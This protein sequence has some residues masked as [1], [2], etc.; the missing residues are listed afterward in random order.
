MFCSRRS[1]SN[2]RVDVANR[3]KK[4]NERNIMRKLKFKKIDAFSS[5]QSS[6]N[7]AGVIYMENFEE[8]NSDEMLKIAKELKD[9][10]SEVGFVC[11]ERNHNFKLRYYSS[12]REVE[13]CG[14]ATIAIMYDLIKNRKDLLNKQHIIINT[15]NDRL[16]V[17][18][19]ILSDNSIFITSPHPKFR[20]L[21]IKQN[22]IL[23]AL[24]V[25]KKMLDL[26]LDIS[27]INSGLE[28]LI[29]PMKNLDSILKVTPTINELKQFCINSKI[30]IVILFSKECFDKTNS[31]RT[32]VF[33]ATFGYLEDPATGSGNSAFG[34]YLLKRELWDG[35]L[36]TIE[37][38]SNKENY[39]TI[40]L[41]TKKANNKVEVL[42]GGSAN[43]KIDGEYFINT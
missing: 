40:K 35:K 22:N 30:D 42:F 11:E 9:F 6:G 41:V 17:E 38:N 20:E 19:R 1:Y 31:Y 23:S 28:T 10:V 14:H 12:K 36:I 8:L 32:R 7:P 29:V 24:R 5:Y 18:N 27:I 21:D 2:Y 37:Q 3:V 43:V 13:F 25:D 4:L 16:V 15:K 34:Q 26:T 39:N 33:A